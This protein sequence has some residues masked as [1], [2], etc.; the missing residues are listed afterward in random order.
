MRRIEYN[1]YGGPEVLKLAEYKLDEPAKDQVRV[2]VKAASINPV[3]WKI[4]DGVLKMMTG[5]KFPR[6]MGEDFAG[7][8][9]AVGSEVTGLKVGD[10]VFGAM[11]M[12][13]AASF[14]EEI[15]T[16][17]NTV[18]PLPAGLSFEEAAILPTVAQTA[19]LALVDAGKLKIGNKVFVN[20]CLGS[21]GRCALQ[22]ARL[23]GAEVSGT[24]GKE[25]LFEAKALGVVKAVDYKT[26]NAEQ[27]RRQFDIVLD[28]SGNLSTAQCSTTLRGKGVA[29][30]INA[31]LLKMFRVMLA[32]RNKLVFLKTNPQLLSKV[33]DLAAKGK[34]TLPV[35]KTVSLSDAIPALVE[36][37]TRG[38]PKGKVVVKI[39]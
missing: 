21:V 23:H 27:F 11:E 35:S 7:V 39:A 10:E 24:C 14:A 18:V 25:G 31:T 4:R 16:S 30:H 1:H 17:T 22:I 33:G 29:L 9:E 38:T 12:K 34:L 3:D 5:K 6:G 2:R 13:E 8:V 15:L 36:L 26:F 19:W 32:S 37:E 20:G 28:A